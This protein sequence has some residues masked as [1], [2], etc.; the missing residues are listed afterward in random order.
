MHERQEQRTQLSAS[1]HS[2]A[3][4]AD[5]QRSNDCGQ[6]KPHEIFSRYLKN[7]E[8]TDENVMHTSDASRVQIKTKSI[9]TQRFIKD[10]AC[11]ADFKDLTLPRKSVETVHANEKPYA[12]AICVKTFQKAVHLALHV[13]KHFSLSQCECKLCFKTFSTHKTLRLHAR[14]HNGDKDYQC[15]WCNRMFL[16]RF[17]LKNHS[18]IHVVTCKHCDRSFQS[19]VEL[20]AH[21]VTSHF[22]CKKC[23]MA[24]SS[25]LRLKVHSQI[26]SNDKSYKCQTCH[27]TFATSRDLKRHVECI[28]R[29]YECR[30]CGKKFNRSSLLKL[31][32]G[33]HA[34]EEPYECKRC[35]MYFVSSS[36]LERH[37]LT[38]IHLCVNE[39]L[40][41]TAII[42]EDT[43]E[44]YFPSKQLAVMS[45]RYDKKPWKCEL[46]DNVYSSSGN[47]R[48]HVTMMH[49]PTYDR[50]LRKFECRLCDREFFGHAAL[51]RHFGVLYEDNKDTYYMLNR[52]CMINSDEANKFGE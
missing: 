52:H 21:H 7:E 38:L 39:P 51:K 6:L 46:C 44:T 43:S 48:R 8:P 14:T 31:H 12:C 4:R 30:Q 37:K 45:A 47:L 5:G 49:G 36:E 35:N 24:F 28:G 16:T 20:V 41:C 27:A 19:S 10:I 22:G 32:S 33:I 2:T 50:N 3:H 13:N 18:K 11:N 25:P 34:G 15:N 9:A 40:D 17:T 1:N 26:H 23:D 42:D 29:L